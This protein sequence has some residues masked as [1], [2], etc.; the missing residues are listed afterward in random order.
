MADLN[1]F[2]CTGRLGGDPELRET[3][4]GKKVATFS[5]AISGFNEETTWLRAKVWDKTAETAKRFLKKGHRVGLAGRLVENRYQDREGIDR[6]QMELIVNS[7]TLLE[8]KSE[9]SQQQQRGGGQRQQQPNRRP[10]QQQDLGWGSADD[11]E[12][13]EIPF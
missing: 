4:G 11:V 5:V 12:V 9:E 3:N 10:P 8:P 6:R 1:N 7:L 13:D 2:S